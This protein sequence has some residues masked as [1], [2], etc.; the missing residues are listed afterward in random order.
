MSIN[1]FSQNGH[2]NDGDDPDVV[3]VTL[4]HNDRRFGFSVVGGLEEGFPPRIDE[5]APGKDRR[6]GW[7]EGRKATNCHFQVRTNLVVWSLIGS[8]ILSHITF[9]LHSLALHPSIHLASFP[10]FVGFRFPSYPMEP[11]GGGPPSFT[12]WISCYTQLPSFLLFLFIPRQLFLFF[13]FFFHPKTVRLVTFKC[14]LIVGSLYPDASFF[15][16]KISSGGKQQ[17]EKKGFCCKP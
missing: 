10:A 4:G 16:S 7:K 2:G 6:V 11:G 14:Q 9:P 1:Y 12:K 15:S 3:Q 5:I 17:Q 8:R 13:F